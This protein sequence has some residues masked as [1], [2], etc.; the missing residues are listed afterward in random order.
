M[1]KS[2][3]LI[4]NYKFFLCISLK[5]VQK[6][7]QFSNKATF[8][9]LFPKGSSFLFVHEIK[10]WPRVPRGGSYLLQVVCSKILILKFCLGGNHG[11]MWNVIGEVKQQN[12]LRQHV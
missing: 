5:S 1:T 12:T 8:S 3:C 11:K 7:H 4:V 2:S 10:P 9:Y 6:L